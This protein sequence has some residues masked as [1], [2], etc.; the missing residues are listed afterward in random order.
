VTVVVR[1]T[2][3]SPTEAERLRR[4]VEADNPE[5]VRVTVEGSE[6]VVRVDPGP[7]ASARATLDDLLACLAVAEQ[8][9]VQGTDAPHAAQ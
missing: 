2:C 6:L 3:G 7:A 5:H 9:G 4:A 1:H 8:A